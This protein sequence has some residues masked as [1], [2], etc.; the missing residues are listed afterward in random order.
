MNAE[1]AYLF[2]H[3]LL[4]TG[5][6]QLQL[7]AERAR[8]H[9]LALEILEVILTPP[10]R[11]ATALELAAHAL[12]ALDE[13]A[14]STESRQDMH[15]RRLNYLRQGASAAQKAHRLLESADA[16]AEL[17]KELEDGPDKGWALYRAAWDYHQVGKSD[18]AETLCEQALALA[19][20]LQDSDLEASC[21]SLMVTLLR[22]TGRQAQALGMQDRIEVLL[23]SVEKPLTTVTLLKSRQVLLADQGQGLNALECCRENVRLLRHHGMTQRLMYELINLGNYLAGNSESG[24]AREAMAESLALARASASDW[25][26]GPVLTWV[27][28]FTRRDGNLRLAADLLEEAGRVLARSG[29]MAHHLNA[30]SEAAAIWHQLGRLDKAYT[31]YHQALAT[32]LELNRLPV[33]LNLSGNLALCCVELGR[34]DEAARLFNQVIEWA[35]ARALGGSLAVFLTNYAVLQSD[36]GQLD[37]AIDTTK[38][39]LE[40]AVRHK[41]EMF[42]SINIGNLARLHW[43]IGELQQARAGFERCV[44]QCRARELPYFEG[45]YRAEYAHFMICCGDSSAPRE[46]AAAEAL[47]QRVGNRREWAGRLAPALARYALLQKDYSRA[48][49]LLSSAETILTEAGI[50][51]PAYTARSVEEVKACTLLAA[52]GASLFRGFRPAC[53]D[54]RLRRALAA[55]CTPEQRNNMPATLRAELE[56]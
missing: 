36:R 12:A 45:V 32:S 25:D 55:S 26:L 6:Y 51:S 14:L 53:M 46:L 2:R 49:T 54:A 4:R 56:F 22:D 15:N 50:R 52:G 44:D 16:H 17:G 40:L 1:Q 23:K 39:A 42:E 41:D 27:G 3:V 31:M 48:H 43:F 34:F 10:E 19:I 20:R 30:T 7:P 24:Q 21:T 29:S 5:A 37:V 47:T 18:L 28:G 8:L 13:A 9:R 38:R 33:W 35:R 11:E